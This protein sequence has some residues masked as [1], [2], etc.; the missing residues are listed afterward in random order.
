MNRKFQCLPILLMFP[1]MFV[2]AAELRVGV[3]KQIITPDRCCRCRAGWG[4][5]RRRRRNGGN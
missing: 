4:R 3:A 2:Q 1:A 5:R